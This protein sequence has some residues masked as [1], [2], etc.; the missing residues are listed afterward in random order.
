VKHKTK[1]KEIYTGT[2][3]EEKQI[4]KYN[5]WQRIKEEALI[6]LNK[7]QTA[8]TKKTKEKAREKKRVDNQV[9]NIT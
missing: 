8:R 1:G 5:I 4:G 6:G 9:P 3:E 7:I 2:K